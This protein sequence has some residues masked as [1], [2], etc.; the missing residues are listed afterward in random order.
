MSQLHMLLYIVQAVLSMYSSA[1]RT[2]GVMVDS[3]DGVTQV[4][5]VYEGHILSH[6]VQRL[7]LAGR[8][9]T[10]YLVKEHSFAT[11]AQ[12]EIVSDIKEKLCYTALD[13]EEEMQATTINECMAL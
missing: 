12:H 6:A 10:N 7:D 5:P 9:L 8:D 13:F 3:G 1:G 2:V 11:T 4:V